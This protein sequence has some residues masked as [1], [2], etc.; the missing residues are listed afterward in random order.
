MLPLH[1][2]DPAT[3][4]QAASELASRDPDLAGIR[5]AWGDPPFW[6][7]TRG[8]PGIVIS[9][10]AQQVSLESAD[11]AYSKLERVVPEITP[12]Q[13]LSLDDHALKKV[14]FSRQKASYVSGIAQGILEGTVDLHALE[15]LSNEHARTS[16]LGLKGVGPWTAD[17]YLLFAM[18]RADA[19]PSGD[20]ALQ[21]AIQDVKSLPAMPTPEQADAI[22]DQWRPWRAVAARMLWYQY[23]CARGRIGS[24]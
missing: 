15:S 5:S 6:T 9:I 14:G 19:W 1:E 11:A 20:L 8:F 7:H 12:Q 24:A 21:K 2:L 18:R 17:A 22:A 23:L 10:L 16:L 3:F 4:G 13:F